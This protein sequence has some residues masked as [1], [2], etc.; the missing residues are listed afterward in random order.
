MYP[1]KSRCTCNFDSRRLALAN[2][3]LCSGAHK[4]KNKARAEVNFGNKIL[5]LLKPIKYTRRSNFSAVWRSDFGANLHITFG[6]SST[7]IC[8]K[9]SASCP[10]KQFG[11]PLNPQLIKHIDENKNMQI[12]KIFHLNEA[13]RSH[14]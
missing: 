12:A 13:N 2:T 14:A 9:L 6:F 4:R 8:T 10:Y 7:N 5:C 1:Q 11:I 3:V